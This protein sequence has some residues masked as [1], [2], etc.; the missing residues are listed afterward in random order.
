MDRPTLCMGENGYLSS[1]P[2]EGIE[3]PI[4]NWLINISQIANENLCEFA[5]VQCRV[6]MLCL[7]VNRVR[8]GVA[9]NFIV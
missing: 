9:S 1:H 4:L 3:P 5:A 2:S 6:V 8:Y 7:F